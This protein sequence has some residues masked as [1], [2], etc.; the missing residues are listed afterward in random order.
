M[1][2]G[3][4]DDIT[5]GRNGSV[6]C[7]FGEAENYSSMGDKACSVEGEITA[8]SLEASTFIGMDP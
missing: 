1:N 6:S 3:I 8:G 4:G 5:R 7:L 2:E